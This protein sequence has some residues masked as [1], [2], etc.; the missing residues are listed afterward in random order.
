MGALTQL[1]FSRSLSVYATVGRSLT[2]AEQVWCLQLVS[3]GLVLGD[4]L[5]LWSLHCPGALLPAQESIPRGLYSLFR[6]LLV[7]TANYNRAFPFRISPQRE[8]DATATVLANRQDESEQS[9]KRLIEQSREFK[10]NTPEVSWGRVTVFRRALRPLGNFTTL[11]D[12]FPSSPERLHGKMPTSLFVCPQP[13]PGGVCASPR[14]RDCG[15]GQ[16]VRISKT[17]VDTKHT[18]CVGWAHEL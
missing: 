10:K 16:V 9:R 18:H 8:L 14:P 12:I 11:T 1:W 5:C 7:E 3:T 13:H 2:D 15:S 4:A 17:S 6:P